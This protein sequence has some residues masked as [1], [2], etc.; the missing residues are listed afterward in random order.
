MQVLK[1]AEVYYLEV[2]F[3]KVFCIVAHD[4]NIFG[5]ECNDFWSN[6]P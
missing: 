5:E 3:W 1:M 4:G 6:K 2:H